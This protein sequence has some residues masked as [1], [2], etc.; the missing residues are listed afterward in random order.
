[1]DPKNNPLGSTSEYPNELH[2]ALRPTPILTT[3]QIREVR[4]TVGHNAFG[5]PPSRNLRGLPSSQSV[6]QQ[7]LSPQSRDT[8]TAS[9]RARASSHT[10][11]SS[12]RVVVPPHPGETSHPEVFP[13]FLENVTSTKES[14]ASASKTQ[15]RTLQSFARK[16]SGPFERRGKNSVD[17]ARKRTSSPPV[18]DPSPARSYTELEGGAETPETFAGSTN[19]PK[20]V[21]F[22][23][24][25]KETPSEK[26]LKTVRRKASRVFSKP[27]AQ[28]TS[29]PLPTVV[30]EVTSG[31]RASSSY[32]R[33]SDRSVQSSGDEAPLYHQ[34]PVSALQEYSRIVTNTRQV[35]DADL[36]EH[37]S[38]TLGT[39]PPVTI[40]QQRLRRSKT[41]RRRSAL[42]DQQRSRFGSGSAISKLARAPSTSE[43]IDLRTFLASTPP[44]SASVGL[45][46]RAEDNLAVEIERQAVEQPSQLGRSPID[47][48]AS[49]LLNPFCNPNG[50]I[51]ARKAR[52]QQ[53]RR[54]VD[55]KIAARKNIGYTPPIVPS[56]STASATKSPVSEN[57][58]SSILSAVQSPL[59]WAKTTLVTY[60]RQPS[61]A[62]SSPTKP[63]SSKYSRKWDETDFAKSFV[64]KSVPGPSAK[65]FP[66]VLRAVVIED[67]LQEQEHEDEKGCQTYSPAAIETA[68]IPSTKGNN[69]VFFH[70]QPPVSET[71][72]PSC[73]VGRGGVETIER[74]SAKGKEGD[75]NY[76]VPTPGPSRQI[77]EASAGTSRSILIQRSGA[78][79]DPVL[80]LEEPASVRPKLSGSL[81]SSE[82]LRVRNPHA[83]NL[84]RISDSNDEIPRTLSPSQSLQIFPGATSSNLGVAT[85]PAPRRTTGGKVAS[86]RARFDQAQSSSSAAA[87]AAAGR[88]PSHSTTGSDP[89]GFDV[90]QRDELP[91]IPGKSVARDFLGVSCEQTCRL[92]CCE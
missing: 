27:V 57:P 88:R 44:A 23:D 46:F 17:K 55:A 70:P 89:E 54:I 50:D 36:V 34:K 63:G 61:F 26:F 53:T 62:P 20:S 6:L 25:P 77:S 91:S 49:P 29:P 43:A 68:L 71:P 13:N 76:L 39:H 85:N 73:Q 74:P 4:G 15:K 80:L 72:G 52:I 56:K 28:S 82:G 5:N 45:A 81:E 59:D 92:W 11:A 90:E 69:R 78:F 79:L 1:M 22:R 84:P 33:E 32:S 8:H 87:T 64:K 24:T 66:H 3:D 86:L 37:D 40:R 38:P 51:A 9:R 41:R 7:Y 58:A 31:R 19:L 30:P 75:F 65:S 16:F 21:T 18:F 35:V 83:R 10:Q 42:Y 67:R 2:P 60:H 47:I 48:I 14:R 12:Q